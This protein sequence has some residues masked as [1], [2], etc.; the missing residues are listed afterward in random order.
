MMR[1][2]G[3]QMKIRTIGIGNMVLAFYTML[4]GSISIVWSRDSV[5]D[6]S[7]GT[8]LLYARAFPWS[9]LVFGVGAATASV[10]LLA[11]K[12]SVLRILTACDCIWMLAGCALAILAA[13]AWGLMSGLAGWLVWETLARGR[14]RRSAPD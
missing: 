10:A 4:L 11:G 3:G 12:R 6:G 9:L 1:P 8:A 5:A 2:P 13:P 14:T 7:S